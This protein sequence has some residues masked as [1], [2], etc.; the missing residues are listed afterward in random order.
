MHFLERLQGPDRERLLA[1]SRP[2]T[3]AKGSFLLRRGE[4]GGDLYLVEQGELEIV[5][6]RARPEI[7]IDSVGPGGIVGEM[8]FLDAAPRA[9]DVR[10]G[11]DTRCLRWEHGILLEVLSADAELAAAFYRALSEG[12]VDRVRDV[13]TSALSGTLGRTRTAAAG[14]STV[15]LARDT[16]ELAERVRVRWLDAEAKLRGA[17]GG[18]DGPALAREVAN[19][20]VREMVGV[21]AQ[22]RE[23]GRG[24]D[25]CQ[26]LA[27][28]LH[29]FLVRAR[30][31]VLAWDSRGKSGARTALLSHLVRAVPSGEG[32]LGQALDAALLALPTASALGWRADVAAAVTAAATE[33][34]VR[35]GAG[36]P[37]APGPGRP[38]R[39]LMING[40][41]AGL[42]ERYGA[43]LHGFKGGVRL[44]CLEESRDLLS[45]VGTG[46]GGLPLAVDLR[47]VQEDLG[48]LVMG[49]SRV[50]HELQDVLVLDGITEYLPERVLAELLAWGRDRLQPGGSFVLTGFTPGQDQA[51]WEGVLDWPQVRRTPQSLARLAVDVGLAD[52]R[53]QSDGAGLVVSGARR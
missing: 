49:Q 27:R 10:A 13:T 19:G 44:T 2:L 28:E 41:L 31:V 9:A 4:R 26:A 24:M 6:T 48:A 21:S 53:V 18:A 5:D 20:L 8:S 40:A 30:T 17:G 42:P 3:V 14:N 51:L 52:V 45:L 47:R 22:A 29:A 37:D 43:A 33:A 38:V 1:A 7:V 23:N 25:A 11:A 32:A 36:R 34:A 16:F 35:R 50:H 12:L 39:V 46:P 15:M